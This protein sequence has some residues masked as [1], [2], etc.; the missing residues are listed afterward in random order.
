MDNYDMKDIQIIARCPIALLFSESF[1]VS[2]K[3]AIIHMSAMQGLDFP[4]SAIHKRNI[5]VYTNEVIVLQLILFLPWLR[6]VKLYS[7]KIRL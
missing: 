4:W 3:V 2:K 1:L 5:W 6:N 7:H